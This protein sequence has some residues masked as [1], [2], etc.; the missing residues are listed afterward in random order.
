MKV[1]AH[2]CPYDVAFLYLGLILLKEK[3]NMKGYAFAGYSSMPSLSTNWKIKN[4]FSIDRCK[5]RR[6]F[7]LKRRAQSF[8]SHTCMFVGGFMI[9]LCC[10]SRYYSDYEKVVAC[11]RSMDISLV[12]SG[13]CRG[14]DTLSVAVAKYYG[15][16]F[17]EF[18]ANWNKFGKSAGIIRNQKMLDEGKPDFVLAFHSD[19]Q[20]GKG[21]LDMLRQVQKAGIPFK[22]I[23]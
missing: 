16:P 3:E 14:A 17:L 1:Y 7:Q 15:I 22:V 4:D 6:Y 18:P 2:I 13:G 21:T 20:N 11:L 12:I 10:G 8:V 19:L 5:N 9:V 23:E